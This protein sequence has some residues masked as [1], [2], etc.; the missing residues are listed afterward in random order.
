M[1]AVSERHSDFT[2]EL[3]QM[4][5]MNPQL[6]MDELEVVAQ[7]KAF[8]RNNHPIDDFCGL[9]PTQMQNWLYAP[10]SELHDVTITTPQDLSAS[11]VMRYLALILDQAA[12]EKGSLKATAKGNLP[13]RLVK[14]ASELLPEFPVARYE[15]DASISE[16]QGSNENKF[17]ALHYTHILAKLAGI[18]FLRSGRLHVKKAAQAQYQKQ[19]ISAFFLPMLEAATMQY[20]W[21]YLDGYPEDVDLRT[22][23]LFM[24]WRL[25]NHGSVDRLVNEVAAAF[26]DLLRGIPPGD[27]FSPEDRLGNMIESRFINRFLQF[28]GFV[29]IDPVVFREGERVAREAELMPLFKETFSF[30]VT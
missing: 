21:A 27:Y 8:E 23:W 24:A 26:P 10:F 17:N 6:T 16:F 13:A 14:Q 29:I 19:G 22:P 1:D 15:K 28:W 18:L 7:Q 9:T 30:S 3:E 20:N 5:A 12:Q 11:P 4:V 25:Q 2:D